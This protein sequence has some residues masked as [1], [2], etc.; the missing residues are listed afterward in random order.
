MRLEWLGACE[1]SCEE[2]VS[3]LPS[4]FLCGQRRICFHLRVIVVTRVTLH[5][6]VHCTVR[7]SG[8]LVMFMI[9]VFGSWV[10]KSWQRQDAPAFTLGWSWQRGLLYLGLRQ[11]ETIRYPSSAIIKHTCFHL[12]VIVAT[13]I[14]MSWSSSI[15]NNSVSQLCYY[16]TD[17]LS[18]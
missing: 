8:L 6:C 5:K 17:L 7:H 14:T 1:Q 16:K 4:H 15:W 11:F 18:P 9:W 3:A 10:F 13:R 12:R 2:E